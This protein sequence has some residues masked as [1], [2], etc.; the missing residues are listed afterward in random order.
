[1][2]KFFRTTYSLAVILLFLAA[3]VL[4]FT[5]TKVFRSY[6]CSRIVNM[7]AKDLH[8]E[9]AISSVQGNLFTGFQ[10]ENVVL[11]Q[12]GEPVITIERLEAKYD[13]LGLLTKSVAVSRLTLV[14][15]VIHLTRSQAGAWNF[16]R[17]LKPSSTDTTP[18]SWTVNLKQ[19]QIKNGA[20]RLID[21]LDL[22]HGARD[23]SL[24]IWPGRFDYSNIELDSLDLDAGLDLRG[25]Q[26]GLTLRSFACQS[27][28]PEFRVKDVAGEFLL[29]PTGVSARK[30]KVETSKSRIRVDARLDSLQIT[31]LTSLAQFQ[32][33]PVVVRLSIERLDFGE[34]KQFIG[35]PIK[36]LERDIAGQI[37]VE[38]RFGLLDVRNITLRTGST[39]VR[40]VGTVANLHHPA[41]LELDLA[42]VKNKADFVDLRHLM[43]TLGIPDLASLG[44]VEYDLRFKGKP[45]AFNARFVGSTAVGRIDVDGSLDL[46]GDAMSYDGTIK[47]EELNLA[48]LLGDSALAS[49]LKTSISFQ[50]RGTR[51]TEMT[52]L[53][54]VEIDSSEFYGL[55]V[56]R[57]V[58]VMD[59]ADATL[60]PRVLLHIGSV[61][62]DTWWG[63][64]DPARGYCFL[65]SQRK[66]QL[67]QPCR[68]NEEPGRRQR[69]VV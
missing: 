42:C 44:G 38:G 23:T 24:A 9:L 59:V 45:T 16:A 33:A 26:V 18:S 41:D 54:R 57:S 25:R 19:I 50:G 58:A 68:D 5:Q 29:T 64:P 39:I 63:A 53:V 48:P 15:P 30:V 60:R 8:G 62:V 37:D 6:L 10:V 21:S 11:R 65:R 46:R 49:N 36:F 67:T 43:P 1:M 28:H 34:L 3:A 4:G 31:N 35:S 69:R 47:T 52:S 61:R 17:L 32:F 27:P 7:V 51:L 12:N 22:A 55:P 2:R 66:D 14:N 20:V 13:P 56:S 40:I